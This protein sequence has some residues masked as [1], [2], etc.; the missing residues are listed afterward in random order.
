MAR[1]GAEVNW[2]RWIQSPAHYFVPQAMY[3]VTAGTYLKWRY[4]AVPGR[5]TMVLTTLFEQTE[6]FGWSLQAWAV[7]PNHY[8]FVAQAPEDA[9][10]LRRML[11]VVHSLTARALNAEDGTAGR[12]VWFQYWDTCITNE[13]SYLARLHYVH[14]N[15]VKHGLVGDAKDYPWCSMRWFLREAE[16]GFQDKV[17]S[18]ECERIS[19]RDDF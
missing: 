18:S 13:R 14:A 3:I 11:Q 9:R 16:P 8:H 2:T 1:G 10:S 5:L 6:R 7:L 12:K 15:P 17:L 4:F 19:I